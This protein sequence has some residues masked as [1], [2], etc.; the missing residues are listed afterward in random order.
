M[1]ERIAGARF[2]ELAGD[3]HIM[4]LGDVATLCSEIGGFVLSVDA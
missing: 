3:D 2:V 1:A 4:W